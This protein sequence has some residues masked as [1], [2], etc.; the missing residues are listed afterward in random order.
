MLKWLTIAAS[1]LASA[2]AQNV[3][4]CASVSV[5]DASAIM[6]VA[7]HRTRDP[8]GCAFEDAA[9]KQQLNIAVIGVASMYE[10]AHQQ[11]P[12]DG[13]TQDEAGLGGPAFSTVPTSDHGDRIALY[14]LKQDKVLIL[15]L[16][17]T[18]ASARLTQMRDLMR[19]LPAK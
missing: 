1:M 9:H 19:K 3:P 8:S 2:A 15:D 11:A 18:G 4:V 13:K 14:C 12:S 6:G 17:A 7:A 16:S 10:R 5:A